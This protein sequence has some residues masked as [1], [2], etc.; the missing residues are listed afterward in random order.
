MACETSTP[1]PNYP[2]AENTPEMGYFDCFAT[3]YD[4]SLEALHIESR[5]RAA[6]VLDRSASLT[7]LGV[8]LSSGMLKKAAHRIERVNRV[9]IAELRR[10]F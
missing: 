4:G 1:Y 9:V 5:A 10:R 3:F 7:V 6:A 2:V 8:D